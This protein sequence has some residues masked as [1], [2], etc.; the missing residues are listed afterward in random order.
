MSRTLCGNEWP[1]NSKIITSSSQGLC[2]AD[3]AIHLLITVKAV[4]SLAEGCVM[5][6]GAA[7]GTKGFVE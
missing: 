1:E 3:L 7:K 5:M 2:H 6:I 4:L